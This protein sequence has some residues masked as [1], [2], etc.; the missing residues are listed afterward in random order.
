MFRE[1]LPNVVPA[2]AASRSSRVAVIIVAEVCLSILGAGIDPPAPTW[3]NIIF[4][5]VKFLTNGRAPAHGVRALDRHLPHRDV[6]QLPRRRRPLDVRRTRGA[7][8]SP[9]RRSARRAANPPNVSPPLRSTGR[10]SRSTTS[11]RTSSRRAASCAPSTA[12][13]SHSSGASTLGIVGESGSGK[14]CSP[15]RS[16][17]CCPSTTSSARARSS[18]RAARSSTLEPNEMRGDLGHPDGD[19]VPG[20]DDRR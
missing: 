15:A 2:M 7:P 19:G 5:G 9:R 20:P 11:R 18:S 1:V 17:A 4:E 13:R 6:A 12:S 16:W 10:C 14:S 3:G 8:V